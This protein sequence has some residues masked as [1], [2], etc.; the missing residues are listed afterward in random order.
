MYCEKRSGQGKI[1]NVCH[2]GREGLGGCQ[3]TWHGGE[4]VM[5]RGKRRVKV[6]DV[7]VRE[8][9]PGLKGWEYHLG[10]GMGGVGEW[11]CQM[12]RCREG[13]DVENGSGPLR[14]SP[15]QPQ[16]VFQTWVT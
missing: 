13:P 3:G 15:R 8:C 6:G 4:G 7:E 9:E 1:W 16:P 14:A 10:A 11:R 2:D 5:V 12:R